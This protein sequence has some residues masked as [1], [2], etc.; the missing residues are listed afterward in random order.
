MQDC[1]NGTIGDHCELCQEGYYGNATF[2]TPSDC[3]ICACPLPIPSNNFARGC[4]VSDDGSRISCQC[5][6]GYYGARCESCSA[7][8]FGRP[9]VIGDTCDPCE[10]SGNI[11]TNMVDSCDSVSGDCLRCLNNTYGAA[12]NLCAPGFFGDAVEKKDCRSCY[13]DQC[14]KNAYSISMFSL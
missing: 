14:G 7:G 3:L 13:C 11:D 9:D 10:C 12:C 8:Y 2:G 4:E 6:P 5:L 1:K